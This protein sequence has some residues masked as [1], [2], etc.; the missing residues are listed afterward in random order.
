MRSIVLQS[1]RLFVCS[2]ISTTVKGL[3]QP[4][5]RK[6]PHFIAKRFCS[7]K[8]VSPDA[9]SAVPSTHDSNDIPSAAAASPPSEYRLGPESELEPR[10]LV[11]GDGDLS[12]S[13]SIAS[14][15]SKSDI[16]LV[17]SVLESEAEHARVYRNSQQHIQ[18]ISSFPSHHLLFETDATRLHQQFPSDMSF[19]R[20]IFNFPHWL[21]KK[22]NNRY[23]RELL[24]NFLASA[25]QVLKQ[26]GGEIQVA[27]RSEQGG[28][29]S[30]DL[31]AWKT[32]WKAAEL[33]VDAGLMLRR[34]DPFVPTY[35]VSSYR[36]ADK[37]FHL[38]VKPER[39]IFT[40]P[41]GRPIDRDLQICYRHELRIML[42]PACLD[43]SPYP[44]DALLNDDSIVLD[45]ARSVAPEGVH[46]E[47]PIRTQITPT[48]G[49]NTAHCPLLVFLLVYGG[50][51]IPLQRM[52][53]DSIRERLEEAV[54]TRLG[55]P[56]AKPGRLVSKPFPYVLL[57]K[58]VRDYS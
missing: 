8:S 22:S 20:I 57:R 2:G 26:N 16:S 23:N 31:V 11:V 50:D 36:G 14:Q 29:H 56:L 33:A 30:E 28:A 27:L 37:K 34:L 42:D 3:N 40:F 6:K 45:I 49:K 55:F 46:V 48:P 54:K 9:S 41:N 17:A 19:D 44:K 53:A 35:D 52:E 47:I 32:S 18:S 51:S 38:G 39:Y 5:I 4:L 10:I 24:G 43:A 15:S 7:Q 21:G 25:S 58:L 12:Y 1:L 13:A